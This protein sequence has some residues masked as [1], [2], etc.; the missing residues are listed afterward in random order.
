MIHSERERERKERERK[1]VEEEKGGTVMIH[2]AIERATRRG[3][4]DQ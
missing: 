2:R 1:R 4:E 3:E